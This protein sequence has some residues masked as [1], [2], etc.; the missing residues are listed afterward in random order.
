MLAT[1]VSVKDPAEAKMSAPVVVPVPLRAGLTP[2]TGFRLQL[3]V[4]GDPPEAVK[5]VMLPIVKEA[6]TGLMV[7]A[8]GV[9]QG[10]FNAVKLTV[11]EAVPA[12]VV[13]TAVTVTGPGESESDVQVQLPV[14]PAV[15]TQAGF[16]GASTVTLA[17]M[18]AVPL[19]AGVR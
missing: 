19:I 6:D 17:P 7:S 3:V 4:P 1:K 9:V 8:E 13:T 11:A 15:T 2:V 16:P 18:L 10:G 14:P 12:M 5:A